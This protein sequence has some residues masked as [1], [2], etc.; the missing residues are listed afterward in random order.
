LNPP[1]PQNYF[2]NALAPTVI[3]TCYVGE[4]ISQAL[5]YTT[6]KRRQAVERR[7]DLIRTPY[8][9]R[10]ECRENV[11]FF[12]NPNVILGSWMRLSAYEADFGWEKPFHFGPGGVCPYDR[13]VISPRHGDDDVDAFMHFQVAHIQDFIIKFWE[14][15]GNA[16]CRTIIEA[17]ILFIGQNSIKLVAF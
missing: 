17:N 7:W 6:H 1:L 8:L 11:P 3:P 2:G 5:S 13:G 12:E 4:I 14:D 15:I 10:G 9:E 16:S